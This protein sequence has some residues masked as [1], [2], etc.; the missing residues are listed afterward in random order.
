MLLRAVRSAFTLIELLVVIAIIAVL[1]AL[2]LPA[3]QQAREAARR[4]QCKNNLK[5]IGLALHN[6]HDTFN[7]FPISMSWGRIDPGTDW[8]R[9]QAFSD[10]VY[11]LPYLDQSPLYNQTNW[12]DFPW[13]PWNTGSNL[14]QSSRLPVF[15]CPSNAFTNGN[16]SNGEF[17]YAINV[18]VINYSKDDINV[19]S[20][21]NA[22]HNGFACYTNWPGE[23]DSVVRMAHVSDGTSNTVAYSEFGSVPCDPSSTGRKSMQMHTWA[24]PGG[25][26]PH[27]LVRQHCLNN[28]GHV[29]DCGRHNGRGSSWASSFIGFGSAYSHNMN[30]NEKPCFATNQGDWRGSTTMSSSSYHTGGVHGL[31][32]DG[33]VRFLSENI[34]YNTYASIGTRNGNETV[35]EF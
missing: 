33:A 7:C 4:S 29:G 1:I 11:M 12:N 9:R 5:Q 28:V 30:P 16:G 17:S 13:N 34:D 32:G 31:M 2:L 26:N 18:G 14:P 20:G 19:I 10:K 35:G 8:D 21:T 23:S 3:V 22:R 15:N 6:Y 24:E 25:A 27:R